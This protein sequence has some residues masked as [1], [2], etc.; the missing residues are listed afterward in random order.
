MHGLNKL[1]HSKSI[2]KDVKCKMRNKNNNKNNIN[3]ENQLK[4][5]LHSIFNLIQENI[6]TW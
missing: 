3:K 1:L 4:D 2:L 6:M 5:V